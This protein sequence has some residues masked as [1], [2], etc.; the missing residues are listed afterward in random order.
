[1]R[2]KEE[3]SKRTALRLGESNM[4]RRCT[5]HIC[6]VKSS[7]ALIAYDFSQ[8]VKRSLCRRIAVTDHSVR[9]TVKRVNGLPLQ[10]IVR[11]EVCIGT[12]KGIPATSGSAL[13]RQIADYSIIPTWPKPLEAFNDRQD[14]RTLQGHCSLYLLHPGKSRFSV[15]RGL[16]QTN[17]SSF[18]ISASFCL[19]YRPGSDKSIGLPTARTLHI[20]Q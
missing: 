6:S 7:T 12:D 20:T 5:L 13:Q 4:R 2:T 14:K 11:V 16:A 9:S 17:F 19:L 18:V 10:L 15:F 8:I 3:T 1:M